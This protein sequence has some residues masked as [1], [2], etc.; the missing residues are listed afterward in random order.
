MKFVLRNSFAL[1]LAAAIVLTCSSASAQSAACTPSASSTTLVHAEGLAENIGDISIACSGG[2]AGSTVSLIVFV[3]LNTNITNRVD[4]NGT[5]QGIT[6][7]L[8]TG[9]GAIPAGTQQLYST[10]SLLLQNLSYT[11]PASPGALV[12]ITVS[13]LRAAAALKG[14]GTALSSITASVTGIGAQFP[15]TSPFQVA[16]PS[17][18]LA[19]SLLNNGI[20]CS[21][22][23][24][25][26]S[27]DFYSFAAA[28][29]ASSTIRLTEVSAAGF[30][31]KDATADTGVRVLIRFSGYSA[32]NRLFVPDA[33]VGSDGTAPTSSGAF[34]ST[35]NGG[36]FSPG[37][38]QLLFIRVNGAD[39]NG[40][41]GTLA[42][43][44]PSAQTAFSTMSEIGLT[45]GSGYA[46][47]EVVSG[48]RSLLEIAQVPVF[49]VA[50]QIPCT[51]IPFVVPT[52][53]AALAPVSNVV[54][55]TVD[56]AIP[57]FAASTPGSDCQQNADC[58][59]IYFPRFSAD[60]TTLNLSG[61][62]LGSRQGANINISNA[63]GGV[64]PY[65]VSIGYQSGVSNWLAVTPSGGDVTSQAGVSLQV[66]ADPSALQPGIYTA[67]ITLSGGSYGSFSVPVTFTVGPPGVTISNVLNAASGAASVAAGS[68]AALYGTNLAG[69]NVSVTFSGL[70]AAIIYSS[71]TQINL[72]VP[73]GLGAQPA[74]DVVVRVDGKVSNSFKVTLA[75]NAPGIFNPG[76]ENADA[77]VN[78]STNPAAN[79]SFVAVYLTGLSIPLTGQVTVNIGNQLNLIPIYA[80]AQPTLT[81][82]DQVDVTIPTA[83][84]GTPNPVSLTICI[85]GAGGQP[86]CSNAVNLYIK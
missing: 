13:G 40:A 16:I 17:V 42:A 33:I 65:S 64:I 41:G 48:N 78:S 83:L 46:V 54:I 38:N 50:P 85:P 61:A 62:S 79:G 37:G 76:I 1:F 73:S 81:A 70:N 28:S 9:G 63:G 25:P 56:A 8:N 30:S 26:A 39:S 5:P 14:N 10:S 47:Y 24:L 7:T 75:P 43:A 66:L 19:T 45:S 84:A 3:T 58:S 15:V 22:V 86:V 36:I 67:T 4:S 55:A 53:T 51:S 35:V 6:V 49:L 69:Q 68:Y 12:T 72:V 57:R 29:V 20:P 32:G 2:P 80:G 27:L 31:S 74:A 82:L 21:G 11:V 18:T 23:P 60:T 59:A 52:V 34:N 77:S 44:I 71:A